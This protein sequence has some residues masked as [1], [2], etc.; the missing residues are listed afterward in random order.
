M[1]QLRLPKRI[2]KDPTTVI[3]LGIVGGWIVAAIF[4]PLLAPYDPLEINLS[5]K[6]MRPSTR[7]LLGADALGRD[8]LSRI[9]HGS[10][11]SLMM[12]LCIV[13]LASLIGVVFGTVSGYVGGMPDEVIMRFTEI[14]LGIPAFFF[15]MVVVIALGPGLLNAMIAMTIVW[16]P[17]Y[18]RLARGQVLSVKEF[19]FVEAARALG[20]PASRI[21]FRHILR[22]IF[23]PILAHM[24]LDVGYVILTATGL[25]FLGLGAQRPT[26]DWGLMVSTGR[27]TL[28][29]AWWVS[30]FPGCAIA[31]LVLGFT[32]LGD[33]LNEAFFRG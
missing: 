5:D 6:F 17:A 2:L 13:T 29:F 20:A 31:S 26:P 25:S 3:A 18:A 33:R 21:I 10:R 8:I 7:H 24:T 15:V 30:T 9:I 27:N 11:I 22:N 28:E 12:S 16:W 1:R 14:F 32:L 23:A 19:A 4:A